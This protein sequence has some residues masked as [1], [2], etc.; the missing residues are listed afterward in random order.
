MVLAL[1]ALIAGGQAHANSLMFCDQNISLTADQQNRILLFSSKIKDLLENSGNKVA[2]ISRSGIDLDRFNIRYSHS[3]IS[4]KDSKNTSWSVRQLYY[5]C[6][7]SK[8]SIYDQGLSGY[9]MDHENAS[10]QYVSIVLIPPPMEDLVEQ[11]A[12]DKQISLKLLGTDYSANAYPFSTAFQNCNQWVMELLAHALGTL[13]RHGDLRLVA[14]N[15]LKAQ[16]YQPTDI[17]IKHAYMMWGSHFLP[18]IHN[19]DH[20]A[21][22]IEKKLYQV[23]MPASV[24]AFVKATVPGASRLELCLNKHTMVV[25][26]GWDSIREH[27]QPG[28][29]DEVVPLF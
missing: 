26:Y 22:N 27:C 28:A 7:E 16:N 25:H 18:L 9:L 23:S 1:L 2:I 3:G 10:S 11:A 15:W 8:P 4:L 24:E 13:D 21:E 6:K 29:D 12:L 19:S 14:Q 20:P 17:D 5:G